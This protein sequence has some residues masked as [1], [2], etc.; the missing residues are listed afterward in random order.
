MM[1]V[2]RGVGLWCG[3]AFVLAGILHAQTSP[4]PLVPPSQTYVYD[5]AG[6]VVAPVP[7]TPALNLG[8][9]FSIEFWMRLDLNARDEQYMRLFYRPNAYE[10]DL[11]PGTHALTYFQPGS[12][13][14]TTTGI[15][16]GQWRHVAIVS[17]NLQVTLYLDA[18]QQ[19]RFT[20]SS[21]PAA[22]SAPLILAGQSYGD[23]TV[24]CCGFPGML[25]QFRIWGR[26]LQSAE[27]PAVASK[28]LAGNESG[29]IADWPFDDGQGVTIRDVGP[30]HVTLQLVSKY[31]GNWTPAW[32][33]TAIVDGGPMF[34]VH[35]L[36]VPKSTIQTRTRTIPID[37]D[38]DGKMDLLVCQVWS[39]T[40]Q[41]CAA[42]RNDGKGNFTDV[43]AQVLGPNPPGFETPRDFCVAD[44]DG[45]GRDDVFIA[46]TGE[47]P[48][49]GYNGG[50]SALLLQTADGRLVD[51]TAAAGLPQQRIFTH[52]VACG[53]IDGDGDVDLYL[54]NLNT[55]STFVPQLYLNDGHGHFTLGEAA[56]L[57]PILNGFSNITARF[58]DVNRDGRLH[59][60]LGGVSNQPHDLLLLNDGHGYFT[61]A[62]DNAV[63]PRYGGRDWSMVNIQVADVDGDG[64][65]DLINAVFGQFYL[66][67]ALQ[68]LL[69]NH[70]G[71]FRDATEQ[72]LQ[73]ASQ[74]GSGT[75][76]KYLDPVFAADFNGDGYLDVLVHGSGQPSHLFLNTGPAGGSRLVDVSELLPDSSGFFGVAD[77]DGNGTA[78]IA[79]WNLANPAILES[80]ITIR[81]FT[82]TPDLIPAVPSGPFF[83][84]G[85]V[86]NSASLSAGVLA[87]GQLI[88][89][90]GRDLGGDFALALPYGGSFPTELSGTRVLINNIAAPVFYASAGSVSA[91][92]P[93]SV[94]PQKQADV[95]VEY[96][97]QRSPPVS[98]F[99][100]RSAPGLFIRTDTGA[101]N[102]LNVDS[103]TGA[104]S[105]NSPGNPAPRGGIIIGYM[106]GAGQTNPPST[107][108]HVAR[109]VGSLAL[110]VEAGLDFGGVS[111]GGLCESNSFCK[112]V[113]VLYAGPVPGLAG[114][115]QIKMRLPNTP[116]VTGTHSLGVSVGGIWSEVFA[117][118]SIR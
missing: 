81:K 28:A 48:S 69:N 103:A 2:R 17:D 30:N 109:T 45:D 6:S 84:R 42:F 57:P 22:S 61:A 9:T 90:L 43:T 78:D 56:R 8:A 99:V 83:L 20:A 96:Q 94:V 24:Y 87:P 38:S 44:F 63:P 108:G 76:L 74:R 37:F 85:N 88:T 75:D 113:E 64:W 68:L 35:S 41:P 25:R 15:A 4:S 52:N 26:A 23:G 31:S 19:G 72:I 36:S 21:P 102:V 107:D 51:A 114:I 10:L 67:G 66:E 3:A 49:C 60:F 95:V 27:I 50:Q 92:V 117:T 34:Q 40:I 12:G 1:K 93:Y 115:T 53:D 14:G 77:F 65:P 116:S 58:I 105:P 55:V 29:L 59:L 97:G 104:L 101:A 5:F 89:I 79:A 118:I 7:A 46:N 62:P 47:C 98:I 80:W 54:A 32:M 112:P 39:T 33:R 73:P 71:T 110:P 86:L 13:G 111:A 106:T 16:P 100:D 82:L 70:D 91:I 18:Q 11:A